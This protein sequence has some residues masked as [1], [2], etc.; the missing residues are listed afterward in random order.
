MAANST[1]NLS[2]RSFLEKDKL[3][4]TNFLDWFRN[5][6]IILKH[7]KKLYVLDQPIPEEPPANALRDQRDAYRKHSDDSLEV[8][9]LMLATMSPD[10]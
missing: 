4:G 3:V 2:L 5:L 1:S 6:R 10:L 7:E 9:C 8:G